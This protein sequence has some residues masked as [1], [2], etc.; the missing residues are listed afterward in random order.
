MRLNRKWILVIALVLSMA[1]AISGTLAYL[2]ATDTATNTFTVGNVSIDLQEPS[3]TG[4]N[5]TLL[6]GVEIAKDPQIKNTGST[7]AWVWMEI[8]VPTD[9]MQYIQG[10]D[11]SEFTKTETVSGANTIVTMKRNAK[12][13]ANATTAA[14]FTKIVL[15]S[16]LTSMPESL[17][18]SGSVDIVV[19]AYA[20]QGNAATTIGGAIEA[21][22]G[23]TG[24]EGDEPGVIYTEVSTAEAL[25]TALQNGGNVK[26]TAN[27]ALNASATVPAGTATVLD[28]NGKILS[29]SASTQD[30]AMITNK[31]NL[32]INGEG[33]IYYNYTGAAD[34]SYGKG[35]Y[36]ISNEG[37][38]TVNGGKI[39]ISN[40]SNHAKYPINN[41]SINGNAVLVINGGHLYNYNT[42]AIRQFCGSSTNTNSVTI[43]GGTIEGY[44]A[45]WM[46]NPSSSGTVNGDLTI[47][48]GTIVTTAKAY[49]EDNSKLKEV[50]SCIYA[51]CSGNGNWSS[52]SFVKIDG[53]TIN[54]NIDFSSEAPA[55]VTVDT[56]KATCNGNVKLASD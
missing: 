13:A 21:Y 31:G 42:S 4:N 46:Q 25:T 15:P 30:E 5:Q 45:I 54:E 12:L 48:G 52:T 8:T 56:S 11:S 37:S 47:S 9:L 28:L 23:E 19:N 34:S 50:S 38:L 44:C 17:T 43:N 26:L 16:S 7:E 33:E 20:I 53:G 27:I 55:T 6:P 14:A 3:Y 40:L 2:T 51:S 39:Y 29:Y 22:N 36:T 41:N 32:T 24:G 10:W 1:T 18:T 35:N 49:V